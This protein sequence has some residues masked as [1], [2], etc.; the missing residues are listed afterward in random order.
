LNRIVW[1]QIKGWDAPYPG[2]KT[3][4]FAPLAIEDEDEGDEDDEPNRR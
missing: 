1:G 4:V 3:A 2:V